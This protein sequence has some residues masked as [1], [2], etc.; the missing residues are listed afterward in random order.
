[1]TPAPD[2]DGVSLAGEAWTLTRA[3]LAAFLTGMVQPMALGPVSLDDG[4]QAI[5]FLCTDVAGAPDISAHGGW[6]RYLEAVGPA[7][8]GS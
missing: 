3:G 2:G 5:G 6:L 1:V 4:T 8:P 7:V